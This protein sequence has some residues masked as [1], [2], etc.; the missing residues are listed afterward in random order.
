MQD[1]RYIFIKYVVLIHWGKS[2]TM[3]R[4]ASP[5]LFF[6]V[7]TD[8]ACNTAFAPIWGFDATRLM[9]GIVLLALSVLDLSGSIASSRI[10]HVQCLGG[11]PLYHRLLAVLQCVQIEQH[12]GQVL[13]AE[14]GK[15]L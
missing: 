1:N 3:T 4:S 10:T 5:L 11:S 12:S 6:S 8:D 7:V 2:F 15:Y 9:L 14:E 13:R